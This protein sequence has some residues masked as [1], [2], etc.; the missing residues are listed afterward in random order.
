M[1]MPSKQERKKT[2]RRGQ[3]VYTILCGPYALEALRERRA[4]LDCSGSAGLEGRASA[5]PQAAS[6]PAPR[7][8]AQRASRLR[9][10]AGR[11]RRRAA[12]LPEHLH[13]VCALLVLRP[14]GRPRVGRRFPAG[15][16]A[17]PLP[18][19]RPP[20][21]QTAAPYPAPPRSPSGGASSWSRGCS[22]SRPA[23][24]PAG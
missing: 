21:E 10:T 23:R 18:A 2:G 6:R 5:T 1:G 14:C 16:Q 20:T 24:P 13:S 3:G 9:S 8:S 7:P 22:G 11:V 19:P 15:R 4:P 12:L 17:L